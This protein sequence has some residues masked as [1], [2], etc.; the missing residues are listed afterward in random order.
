VGTP[1]G[2]VGR[3]TIAAA[4]KAKRPV[5]AALSYLTLL[6]DDILATFPAGKLPPI[7]EVTLFKHEEVKGYLKR[8]GEPGFLNPFRLWRPFE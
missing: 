7:E 8:P 4:E 5:A 6:H 3:A 1:E 2:V